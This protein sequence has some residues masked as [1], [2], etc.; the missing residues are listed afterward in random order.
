[1]RQ[2]KS[3]AIHRSHAAG[4]SLVELLVV[5]AIIGAMAA[6]GLPA[7]GRYIRNFRIKGAS[8]QVAMEMNVARSKAITK[9]V[10]LGVVFAVVN[11]TQYR[12]VVEDDQLPQTAPNWSGISGEDWA[13]LIAQPT[14]VGVLQSLPT[15]VSFDAPGNCPGVGSGTDT[16]GVRF[17]Q[18][19]ATC[20]FG[21]GSCGAAP[22]NAGSISTNYIRALG[23]AHVI[24][25]KENS[26]SLHKTV[27]VSSG[28]RVLAEP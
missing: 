9:N 3:K 22:P 24:C 26:T 27:S 16:W 1:M 23:S 15:N 7:V 20:A 28:G 6:V 8:Q 2:F 19:G 12:W 13:T 10:N 25:L 21:S 11:D 18:L 5:V 14:Q 17:T 4:F